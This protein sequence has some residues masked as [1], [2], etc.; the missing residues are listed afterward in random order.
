MKE[1]AEYHKSGMKSTKGGFF[2]G[3]QFDVRSQA[4][5]LSRRTED[6][7]AYYYVQADQ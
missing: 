4:S 7:N 6:S 2:A 1:K 3:G 5:G